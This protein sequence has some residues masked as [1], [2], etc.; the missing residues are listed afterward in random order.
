[1]G[2]L[3]SVAPLMKENSTIITLAATTTRFMNLFVTDDGRIGR[4]LFPLVAG[5]VLVVL[6]GGKVPFVLRPCK[7]HYLL[8]GECYVPGIMHGEMMKE[9]DEGKRQLQ[10]FALH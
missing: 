3:E 8:L 2:L 6:L 7:E 1:M 9:L 5:D 10:D 4:I